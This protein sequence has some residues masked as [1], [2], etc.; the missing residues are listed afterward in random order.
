MSF[1]GI[2]HGQQHIGR[3]VRRAR[4]RQSQGSDRGQHEAWPAVSN[5]WASCDVRV[6]VAT[7]RFRTVASAW[8]GG[9]SPSVFGE[10]ERDLLSRAA[11]DRENTSESPQLRC[12]GPINDDRARKI[13]PPCK[14]KHGIRGSKAPLFCAAPHTEDMIAQ[15]PAESQVRDE[16][17]CRALPGDRHDVLDLAAVTQAAAQLHLPYPC[18]FGHRCLSLPAHCSAGRAGERGRGCPALS[19]RPAPGSSSC[20]ALQAPRSQPSVPISRRAGL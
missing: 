5:R 15:L 4:Q 13:V 17:G 9:G 18:L 6:A 7:R 10:F 11:I 3:Y 2:G 16:F 1:L 12:A 14:L 8:I 19:L 20:R